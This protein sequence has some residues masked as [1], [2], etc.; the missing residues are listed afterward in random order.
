MREFLDE[1]FLLDNAAGRELYFGYA[2]KLPIYDYHCHLPPEEIAVDRRFAN[3]TEIWLGGDHY[4]WRA[5]RSNGIDER[6][7]TGNAPDDEKFRAWAATVPYCI[8]NPLYHWTHLELQRY[9]GIRDLLDENSAASIWERCNTLLA[10][11]AFSVKNLLRRSNVHTIMTT[12]DPLDTLSS[13]QKIWEDFDFQVRVST[14]FRPDRALA[15]AADEF[16]DWVE[17]LAE[18]AGIAIHDSYH[19][20]LEALEERA[21]FFHA[22]GCQLSDH[23]LDEVVF[24]RADPGALAETF[25][26]R[27][28]GG[29][30]SQAAAEAFQ[31]ETLLF[32]GRLYHELDWAMQLHIGALRFNNTRMQGVFGFDSIGDRPFAKPLALL[33]D[34]LDQRDELPRT[35][36]YCLNPSDNEVVATMI[37]N[38]Q[39]SGVAGKIQFG[40]GWWFNDQEDGILRQLQALANLGLLGRFVGMLTDSRSFLSYPRHEY[41]RRILCNLLGGWIESGRA[42]RDLDRMGKMVEDICFHNARRYFS[43]EEAM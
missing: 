33:L 14:A 27:M 41:F 43:G 26:R 23:A 39:G 3:L 2:A 9:F 29:E 21:R 40:S 31:T 10:T 22:R 8:G 11:E 16:P 7:V 28:R 42:P 18:S 19:R 20:F 17:R 25:R 24:E 30:I 12:E 6:F 15:I 37:G 5:M 32:L 38:F 1:N 4:K 36:L 34:A 35:I 13:H